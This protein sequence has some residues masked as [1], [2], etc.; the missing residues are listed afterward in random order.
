MLI[1]VKDFDVDVFLRFNDENIYIYYSDFETIP[2]LAQYIPLGSFDNEGKFQLIRLDMKS[3]VKVGLLFMERDL[4][5]KYNI[6]TYKL[7]IDISRVYD[8]FRMI[9]EIV[10]FCEKYFKLCSEPEA[11]KDQNGNIIYDPEGNVIYDIPEWCT[12]CDSTITNTSCPEYCLPPKKSSTGIPENGCAIYIPV[13]VFCDDEYD[14]NTNPDQYYKDLYYLIVV[15]FN[16]IYRTT[17]EEAQ[18][19]SFYNI[20]TD[21]DFELNKYSLIINMKE[22]F[23]K[24]LIYYLNTV[25]GALPFGNDFGTH[26]KEVIQTKNLEVKKIMV[27]NEIDF[28]VINFNKM[29]GEFVTIYKVDIDQGFTKTGGDMW[30]VSIFAQVEKD[31]LTY[32]IEI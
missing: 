26:L 21:V 30:V 32:R 10:I 22:F 12:N 6:D 29:W 8:E 27:E 5:M 16:G 23:T 15:Y 31:R 11:K 28:F 3:R 1:G 25:P 4:F 18:L 17:P 19:Y 9:P 7:D 20:L 13:D 24:E 14:P 2:D